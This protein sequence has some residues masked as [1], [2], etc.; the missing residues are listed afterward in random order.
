M[1]NNT[2]HNDRHPWK[3]AWTPRMA[4]AIWAKGFSLACA[5]FF[6]LP[7]QAAMS[8]DELAKLAQNPIANL[9]SGPC[10]LAQ[11]SARSS[12]SGSSR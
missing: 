5:L 8:S 1:T 11:A 10:P 9:I 3:Q 4:G 12:T 2:M 7:V 6:A